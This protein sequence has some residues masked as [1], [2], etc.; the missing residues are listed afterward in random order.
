M[1]QLRFVPFFI[2]VRHNLHDLFPI[3]TSLI[4]IAVILYILPRMHH[5]HI[6]QI[7]IFRAVIVVVLHVFIIIVGKAF[8][9]LLHIV[10]QLVVLLPVGRVLLQVFAFR[11]LITVHKHFVL[12]LCYFFRIFCPCRR[13]LIPCQHILVC[14]CCPSMVLQ[15]PD[16]LIILHKAGIVSIFCIFN[17]NLCVS[18]FVRLNFLIRGPPSDDRHPRAAG[19]K[20]RRLFILLYGRKGETMVLPFKQILQLINRRH[21]LLGSHRIAV[22]IGCHIHK[23]ADVKDTLRLQLAAYHAHAHNIRQGETEKPV[24]R[25]RLLKRR[26]RIRIHGKTQSVLCTTPADLHGSAYRDSDYRK[27]HSRQCGVLH[28]A[29]DSSE[30]ASAS[31][32]PC[33]FLFSF[34]SSLLLRQL[35]FFFLSGCLCHILSGRLCHILLP[36]HPCHIFALCIFHFHIPSF[37]C[38]RQVSF[39]TL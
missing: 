38:S 14:G 6:A 29:Q 36:D 31:S 30:T 39:S 16:W 20:I 27:Y 19:Q 22:I 3:R 34:L 9:C 28:K 7:G 11:R 33:P 1:R 15:I 2:Q 4:H 17:H 23:P 21:I 32:P 5:N 18:D 26:P 10:N 35:Y 24:E 37:Q 25:L 12:I 8:S 13:I